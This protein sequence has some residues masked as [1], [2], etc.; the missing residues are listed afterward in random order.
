M[1]SEVVDRL[2]NKTVLV[3][4]DLMLDRFV[5]GDIERISPEAPIPVLRFRDEKTMLG[6]AGNVARNIV[7]LGGRAVLAGVVGDDP[8]G[9]QICEILCPDAGV[10]ARIITSA[11]APT[12]I[13]TR[14]VCEGQQMLRVD[15]EE[16]ILDDDTLIRSLAVVRAAL[17]GV[18]AMVLSDYAKGVLTP[19]TIRSHV[20]AAKAAGVPVIVDPKSRDLAIY[21]D[22]DVITPNAREAA[23]TTGHDCSTDG[24]AAKAA[25][26]I[27]AAADVRAVL[28]TR[29][30]HGMTLFAPEAGVEQPLH[31]PT[32]ASSVYDVS[33][34]GDTVIATLSLALAA[35]VDIATAAR[36]ANSAAGIVVGKLGT[37]AVGAE[38]LIQS[39]TRTQELSFVTRKQAELQVRRWHERG[40]KVGFAN[41][42]F[43]LVHPGH[44]ALLQKA[45][46]QCD[47]LV[48]ALNTDA[49]IKRLKGENRPVQDETSRATVIGSLR[50]VDLVTLFDEDTPL[51]LIRL[52]KPDVLIKGA[53]YKLH[54]VVGADIIGQ[55]GGRVSLIPLEAGHSTTSI[56]ARSEGVA[57]NE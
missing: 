36:L 16:T 29:G 24:G 18:D 39:V 19:S 56:I 3:V 8:E 37:A 47:R 52:L 17:A 22:V 43:D 27:L 33:G 15:R 51:D 26:A 45:R 57:A 2:A 30:A 4:G 42:C 49:S 7:A 12:V 53:D 20:E 25:E 54:E 23:A 28:I 40:L 5:Y 13:K 50:S 21:R 48:V 35:G 32:R 10:D 44:V 31:I 34:A 1:E 55:W 46:E 38:E 6:G 14:F 9:A 41:G 11:S